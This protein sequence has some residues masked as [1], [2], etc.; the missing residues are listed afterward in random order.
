MKNLFS[1]LV[2]LLFS[3]S[4]SQNKATDT[5]Q[6]VVIN[7]INSAIAKEKPYLILISADGYRYDYTE[8]Y[9]A[10]NLLKFSNQGVKAKA[11]I[12][13]AHV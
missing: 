4:F 7:R 10:E 12:G 5:A 6:V 3:F 1:I 8:K 13:R 9:N 2:I 11:K